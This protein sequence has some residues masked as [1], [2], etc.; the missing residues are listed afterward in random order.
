MIVVDHYLQHIPAVEAAIRAAKL[1]AIVM[2]LGPTAHLLPWIDQSLLHGVRLWGCND[3]G[4][5]MA[6]DDLVIMDSPHQGLHPAMVRFATVVKS[7][8]KRLWLHEP[9]AKYWKGLIPSCMDSVTRHEPFDAFK[10]GHQPQFVDP[11]RLKFALEAKPL[12]TTCVSPTG[13]ATLAWREGARRIGIIGADCLKGQHHTFKMAHIVDR[14]FCCVAEQAEQRGG[15]IVNLSPIT[16]LRTFR[17]R[18]T[19]SA[20]LSAPTHGSETLALNSSS[21]TPSVSTPP[22]PSTSSGCGLATSDGPSAKTAPTEAGS[23]VAP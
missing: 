7:R 6:V 21:N 22:A 1:D 14:F 8:P 15:C 11:R 9:N 19:P 12:Q 23:S 18:W 3:V 5:I 13:T 4:S 20:S 17:G 10:P 2:G 16:S